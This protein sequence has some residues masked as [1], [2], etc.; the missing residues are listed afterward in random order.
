MYK[1]QWDLDTGGLLLTSEQ[2]SFSKEPR[3]VYYK[4]LDILGFDR[5]WSYPKD[6]RAP[7]MWAEANNYIYK[8]RTVAKTKGGSLYTAPELIILDEPE[9]NGGMLQFV[10]VEAMVAKNQPLM[11]TLVQETI[12]KIYNTYR[13]YKEKVDV[14]YV[15]F[16]G[17][18]DSVVVLDLVQRALP[19]NDFVVMFGDTQMEFPDTYEVVNKIKAQCESAGI[20]FY[21]SRA[22]YTPLDSWKK[23]GPPCTVT[24]W[25]CSVHKTAPQILL[26][27]KLL[28]KHDFVGMAYVGVRADES[29][30]R[31]K[32]NFVSYGGKHRGQYSCNAILDW[33]SA[34]VFLYIYMQGLVLNETYKKG[35]RR[36]GCLICPRAAGRNDFMNHYCYYEEAEQLIDVIR[37]AYKETFPSTDKLTQFIEAGGWKARKNGRDLSMKVHYKEQRTKKNEVIITLKEART[38][39]KEWIKTIGELANAS[40]PYKIRF[41]DRMLQFSVNEDEGLCVVV[42]ARTSHD[43]PDFVKMLKNVFRKAGYCVGCRVCQADCPYG[44]I[45]FIDGQVIIDERCLHCSKCHNVEKGCLVYKSLEQPKG[46]LIMSG[47]KMSLNSYSHHAPR[48]EWIK[49]YFEY[50]DTF[51]D[52]HTLG[53]DMYNFFKRFL[54]DAK[55]LDKNGFTELAQIVDRLGLYN[56]QSWG[57]IFINLCYAPQVHWFVNTVDFSVD[58]SKQ[59]LASLMVEDGAKESWTNDIFSSLV[60]LTELPLGEIGFGTAIKNKN[61]AIAIRRNIWANPDA[62]VI[63]YSLYKFAEA[64]G[65]YYQFSLGTLL[66]D[67]VERDGVSPTRIFGLNRE[68]MVRILNGLSINYP[69]FISVSFTLNLDNITLRSD[70]TSEDVLKLF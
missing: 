42:D 67:S 58:Y 62:K 57:I 18:K 14:F 55:L 19:H 21:S 5:Y 6:D 10:D 30:T 12:Q 29:V 38:D 43:N 1:Y 25:C 59:L 34:E 3:P 65:G 35:N 63:L 60:R 52:N 15:A 28:N 16:S 47:K 17:G 50:K 13:D 68:T 9:P 54:R 8:G 51:D 48:M 2:S 36:A 69:E 26:L 27:R 23:F 44:Y 33:S 45:N 61:R 40:S 49:Q 24:R 32:Y 66:D 70:K 4:E 31:S 46:G 64:C 56:T 11:E 20:E 37:N 39:W 53:R 7:L 41:H 22:E